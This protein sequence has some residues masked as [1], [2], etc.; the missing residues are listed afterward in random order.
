MIGRT[1]SHYQVLE[2]LGSGGMGEIF[3]AQDPRLARMV[4]IKVLSRRAAPDEERRRRFI[5]E[6]QAASSLNHPNIIT[7]YDILSDEENEYMVMEY[8]PG[9]TLTDEISKGGVEISRALQY[10]VQIADA[11]ASAHAAGIVHR[12]LKPGNVMVTESGRIKILDFGLAKMTVATQLSE[13]TETIGRAPMTVEGS[14]IGTVSYMSPEQAEGKRVDARSDIFSFGVVLYEL[15]TGAKA[16]AGD[17]AVS[18]L[19]AILRDPV[20]PISDY[21]T[22]IPPELEEIVGRSLRKDPSQRWQSMKE[23]HTML[24][25]L[26]QKYDSGVLYALPVSPRPR[27]RRWIVG[28]VAAFGISVAIGAALMV[29][30]RSKPP[31]A[32]VTV[33]AA[34]VEAP[35]PAPPAPAPSPLPKKTEK[36]T[37]SSAARPPAKPDNVLTNQSVIDMVQAKVSPSLMMSLIRSSKSK[38]DFSV[39]EIIR[40]TKAGVPDEVIEVMRDPNAPPKPSPPDFGP[41]RQ[42]D[43]GGGRER[44]TIDMGRG[45][46][47]IPGFTSTTGKATI[48]GGLPLSLVLLDDIPVQPQEGMPLHFRVDQELRLGPAALIAKGA[49]V[50]GEIVF[51]K[52]NSGRPPRVAFKL[53]TVEAAD[54]TKLKVR[55]SPGRNSQR[56][57]QPVEVP[58]YTYKESLAPA[59]TKYIAYIDGDQTIAVKK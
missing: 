8:V 20:R 14:I 11:L 44:V 22:G 39:P 21:V 25:A 12:D 13:D 56:N 37:S 17:S 53:S 28:A 7:I 49:A 31:S 36:A 48:Y 18:T 15:I 26:R 33:P 40:M 9:R 6:A 54:G 30:H 27:K 32:P 2:K 23:I 45:L 58:G 4:A 51:M 16:F 42:P 24:V 5:K 59:G 1:I 34:R 47:N 55:A 50:T 38:F 3:K 35:A 10:G 19:T 57:E 43:P 46:I 52:S 41:R 29:S